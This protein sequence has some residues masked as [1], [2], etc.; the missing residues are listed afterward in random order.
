MIQ[1]IIL[2]FILLLRLFILRIE[3]HKLILI[4]LKIFKI[5]NLKVLIIKFHLKKKKKVINNNDHKILIFI[6]NK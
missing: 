5:M 6:R 3:T 4:R 2:M 1:T